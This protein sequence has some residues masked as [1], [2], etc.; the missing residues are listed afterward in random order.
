MGYFNT[1]SLPVVQT[2]SS[3]ENVSRGRSSVSNRVD[4]L[5]RIGNVELAKELMLSYPGVYATQVES[6]KTIAPNTPMFGKDCE[7]FNANRT[8]RA[9]SEGEDV[10]Q[11]QKFLNCSGFKLSDT[12]PGSPGN[13]TTLFS[14]RTHIALA[15]FQEYYAQEILRLLNLEK[16]SG[17]LGELSR[18]KIMDLT[19]QE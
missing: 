16:G 3:A 10:R 7:V 5:I 9:G 4:N 15:K 6:V 12:G 19:S 17:V 13:E 18:K 2:S 1:L 14:V 11:L 8:L